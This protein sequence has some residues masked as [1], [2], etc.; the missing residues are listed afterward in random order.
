MK[1]TLVVTYTP[2]IDSNTKKLVDYFLD[3]NQ[4]NTNIKILDLT[5]TTP[6]LLLQ[7]NLNLFLKR[8][9]GG[10]AL[11]DEEVRILEKNDFMLQQV[12]D[13]DYVVLAYPMYNFSLPATVKAWIDGITQAGKTFKLTETGYKGLCENKKALVLMTTGSDFSVEPVKS[14]NY[15]TP[16]ISQQ[17]DFIG[18]PTEHITAFGLQQYPEKVFSILEDSKQEIKSLSDIWYS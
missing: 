16:L 9:Y 11:E 3:Y 18:I 6:D 12:L 5:E 1:K 7:E 10:I 13:A 14:M 15:A 17:F 4:D 8:N 2:R